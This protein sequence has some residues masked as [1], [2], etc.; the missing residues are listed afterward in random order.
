[1]VEASAG[2]AVLGVRDV[3][4]T[5]G[6]RVVTEVLKGIDLELSE[7]EFCAL[8]GP[9]GSG[10]T[11]L[12]NLVG[13]LDR[14]TS[15]Q[16]LIDGQDTG[17]LS[18]QARTDLRGT[19]LGFVFQFHHLLPAF[20]AIENVM[21]PLLARHGRPKPWMRERASALLEQ[22]GLSH[23]TKY[24]ATDLSGGEQQRVAIARALVIDPILV[25]ADEPTGNLDS[26]TSA[27]V[28]ELLHDF[29]IRSGTTFL[30][31]THEEAIAE[32][33]QRVIH[34]IDGRVAGDRAAGAA[35]VGP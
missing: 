1:M 26:E 10:K 2:R 9:S 23:R 5:Y 27:Y 7:G 16:I 14:P 15:G 29:N 13:L 11:T 6:E 28:M 17:P 19:S 21:M 8:T 35:S 30:I 20:S 25:L 32:G 34:M 31:V 33:C 22:V 3:R 18:E 12:M 4:K 24:R